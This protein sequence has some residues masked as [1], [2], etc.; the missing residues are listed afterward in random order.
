MKRLLLTAL[1][2]VVLVAA[3]LFCIPNQSVPSTESKKVSGRTLKEESQFKL[4]DAPTVSKLP[5]SRVPLPQVTMTAVEYKIDYSAWSRELSDLPFEFRGGQ[6]TRGRIVDR[7]GNVLLESS[8]EIRIAGAAV[9][10]DKKKVLAKGGDGKNLILEP[11]TN[12][13]ITPPLRPPGS[14]LFPF[15]WHWIG[16]NLLFGISGVQ[17]IFHEGPHENC[18][19]DNNVAQT[20][21]YTFDLVTEQLSEV[22]MPDTVTQ[23]LVS[24]TEVMSDGHIHLQLSDLPDDVDPDLGW[25]KI[26]A[27]K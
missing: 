2:L 16:P 21:F 14:N 20:K 25:F 9:S 1:I 17:K 11:S 19:N 22:V 10:P 27:S 15:D 8:E 13:K 5:T 6:G 24:A 3:I 26:D 12:R 18:C 4:A 7:Q 23:P